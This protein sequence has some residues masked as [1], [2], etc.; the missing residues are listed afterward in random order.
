[1]KLILLADLHLGGTMYRTDENGVNR[2][3]VA[4]Y[5][6]L[7]ENL[8]II[9][10]EKPDLLIIAGDIFD[11]PNPSV[12]AINKYKWFVRKLYEAEIPVMV[13]IGN[14]DFNFA[15]RK[16]E[17]S[18]PGLVPVQY[19]ADYEIK[20]VEIDDTLFV[21]MPYIYDTEKNIKA[22]MEQVEEE[23]KKSDK[24]KKILITHG[25]VDKYIMFN[26]K[27][28]DPIHLSDEIVNLFNVV[29]IGHIH[30]PFDFMIKD[31]LVLSPG[32]LI[33]YQADCDR[34][35]PVIM[36]TADFTF[37]RRLVKTPHIIKCDCDETNINEV[38][39]NVTNDIYKITY[40]GDSSVI[41]NDLFIQARD[42]VINI[43]IDVTPQEE[44][45]SATTKI[46]DSM[47][48][49]YEYVKKDYPEHYNSFD[50]AREEK[51]KL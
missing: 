43:T 23:A 24:K 7:K 18:A 34:T 44:I 45:V 3:E 13:I 17:C 33:D 4:G 21:M 15:N 16:N 28:T 32:G 6:A 1:M 51:A 25:I 10:E 2:Y 30:T 48:T 49:I 27:I 9:L 20:S 41:D 38:L 35:G 31:T 39:K 22:Y 19:F 50:V 26:D 8:K 46:S 5:K 29:V 37:N 36:D 14:H 47:P 40:T 42:K 12:Y 11:K